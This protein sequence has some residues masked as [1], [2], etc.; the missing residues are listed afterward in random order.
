[1]PEADEVLVSRDGPVTIIQIHRPA[2]RNAIR[3]STARAL[4]EAWLAF[5]ADSDAA[6]AVLTGGDDVFCAGADLY[7]ADELVADAEGENGPL[8]FTR[9]TGRKPTIAAIAGYCVAGGLE[10]ACWCD[11]RIADESAVFGCFERR[12]GVPLIDGGTQRLPRIVGLGRALD[13]ILTGRAVAAQEALAMGLVNE[14][15]PRGASLTRAVEIGRVVAGF[16]RACLRNDRQAVYE[17]IAR[18]LAEGLRIEA[19]LGLETI[20]SGE[21]AAGAGRFAAGAGR[22]GADVTN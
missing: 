20:R 9:L 16:P 6:V 19:A 18:D 8:G 13:M 22:G 14:V 4:R 17:G 10:L 12:F 3:G 15:T 7:H 21:T 2:A 5:E 11:L 1:M